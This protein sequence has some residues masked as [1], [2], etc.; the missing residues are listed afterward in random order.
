MAELLEEV[1]R[2]DQQKGF[3]D[4]VAERSLSSFDNKRIRQSLKIFC[5]R[6]LISENSYENGSEKEL[7]M[8]I[9]GALDEPVVKQAM[10]HII[11]DS[12]MIANA[13]VI[14]KFGSEGGSEE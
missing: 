11:V 7:E 3:W 10:L 9:R 14:R 13:L 8:L 12:F 1:R 4:S 5:G 2:M 6:L